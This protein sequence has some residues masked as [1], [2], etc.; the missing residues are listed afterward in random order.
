MGARHGTTAGSGLVFGYVGLYKGAGDST[1]HQFDDFKVGFDDDADDTLDAD[2][3]VLHDD[4]NSATITLTHDD[5]GNLTYDGVYEY[6][7]DF[8]NRLGLTLPQRL[9]RIDEVAQM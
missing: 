8:L 2:E 6:V 4:F 5:N 9:R 1:V 7:Y 3:V